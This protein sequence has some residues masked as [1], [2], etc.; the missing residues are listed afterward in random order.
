MVLNLEQ[1]ARALGGEISGNQVLAPGPGHIG[2]SLHRVRLSRPASSGRRYA[3][4]YRGVMSCDTLYK[5][6][7]GRF[8]TT[9]VACP[10]CGPRQHG[11]VE[12]PVIWTLHEDE[13]A[14][15]PVQAGRSGL[16]AC[17]QCSA[18]RTAGKPCPNCGFMPKRPGE[19]MAVRDGELQHLDRNGKLHPNH[20]NDD[21]KHDFHRMLV[22][23]AGQRGYKLGWSTHKF[24]ER[25]GHWPPRELAGGPI[26]PNAEV[27]A[28]E[29]HCRIKFAKAMAK[30]GA[31][32]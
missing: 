16:V 25:F 4:S 22:Y 15:A 17:S 23:I 7:R 8:G 11:F 18:I 27:L 30:A 9:D 29:R 31:D 5:L 20:Y 6:S 1:I 21:Q 14:E 2:G 24:K 19:Y 26:E 10:I 12:E 13:R 3:M 28:W 32:G